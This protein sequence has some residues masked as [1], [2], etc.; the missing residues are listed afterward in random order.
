ICVFNTMPFGKQAQWTERTS[1]IDWERLF[2]TD[3]PQKSPMAR[4][5]PGFAG[6]L[7]GAPLLPLLIEWLER[8]RKANFLKPICGGGGILCPEDAERVSHAGADAVFL[9]S[10][11]F[12]AP[13]QVR[14]TIRHGNVH[15]GTANGVMFRHHEHID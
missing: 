9:G 6:G 2:G 13:R 12:L 8:A 5:F 4:R 15:C 1:P 10:I 11:A 3:D 7:S 14:R